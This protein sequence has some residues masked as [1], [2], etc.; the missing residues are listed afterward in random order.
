MRT[1]QSTKRPNSSARPS[2]STRQR[3]TRKQS[4]STQGSCNRRRS[5][6]RP[7]PGSK[8]MR[9]S[10]QRARRKRQ[11]AELLRRRRE[12]RYELDDHGIQAYACNLLQKKLRLRDHSPKCSTALLFTVLLAAAAQCTSIAAACYR[13]D[14]APSDQTIYNALDATLPDYAEL[15]RRVNQALRANLP[16]NLRKRRQ[17]LAIDL[18]LIPY[19]GEPQ[20][21]ATEIYRGKAKHGTTHFH[22]YA[23]LYVVCR[24]ERFTVALVRVEHGAAMK[25]VVQRLL[26]W[27]ARAGVRP[28]LLLLDRGFYSMD[29]IGYLK[30]ARVPFLM[31]AVARGRRPA[32]DRPPTGIRAF[33]LLKRG[34]WG[35]HTLAKGKRRER[36]HVCVYAGN[37]RGQW[38]RHGRFAWVY[39]YWGFQPSSPRWVA[40]T[41]RLR[42]GIE[43]SYRQL[44]QGRIKTCTRSPLWRYLFVAIALILR[45]LWV[46]L[47]WEVLST[48]RRGRRR[49][50]L[51]RLTLEGMLVFLLHVAEALL[52][53]RKRVLTERQ[54]PAS[55]TTTGGG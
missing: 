54:P 51:E 9:H 2:R 28:K 32:A 49:L 26:Q 41:Y 15:E 4:S 3:T 46:W 52:G 19:H 40:D 30:R 5:A 53:I 27:G 33:Q 31:P 37:Y 34:G 21:E 36:V 55:L 43:T 48:P 38:R 12:Q 22:A 10:A 16:R 23:S 11:A 24:G 39:A 42:F 50:N 47:H 35:E 25:G 20:A 6:K 45:N 14:K 1:R 44:N 18:T 8:R 7:R 17:Y 13:L 29:V